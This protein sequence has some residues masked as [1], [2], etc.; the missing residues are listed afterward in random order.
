MISLLAL[1]GMAVVLFASTNVDDIFVLVGFFADPKLRAR[2]IVLGQFAGIGTLFCASL[3]ASLLSLKIPHAYVGLLGVFPILIGG[4]DLFNLYRKHGRAENDI[5]HKPIAEAKGRATTVA[6][7][8]MANGGDNIAIYTPWFAIRS[9]TE[10]AAIAFVFVVMTA[11]WCFI[12]QALVNHPRL[13]SPIRRYGQILSPFVL[14]GLGVLIL[15][16]SGSFGLF[17]HAI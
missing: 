2:D 17:R 10:M 4:K 8:T 13:G 14:I 3:A 1:T 9:A 5:E 7:V 12:A 6:M 11:L 16:Q 15:Y